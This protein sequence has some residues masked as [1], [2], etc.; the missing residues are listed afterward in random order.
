MI[1][2]ESYFHRDE[3]HDVLRRWIHDE[4]APADADLITRLVHFNSACV[5]RYLRVFSEQVLQSV[6]GQQL[7]TRRA[8]VKSCLKDAIIAHPPYRNA[9]VDELV[10]QYAEHPETQYRET[11]F[12]ATLYFAD[13]GGSETYVGSQRVKRVRRLAE[14]VARRIADDLFA[15][16]KRRADAL[17]EARARAR[18]I[19]LAKLVTAHEEMVAEFAG[20]EARIVEDLRAGRPLEVGRLVI[21]DVAGLKVIAEEGEYGRVLEA[22]HALPGAKVF[23]VE[24]HRGRYNATNVAVRYRPDKERI[25]AQPPGETLLAAMAGRGLDAAATRREFEAFVRRAEDEV[26]IEVI[27]SSYQEML[28]S[29]IG[30]C[31]HEDR[32]LEQRNGAPY[33]GYLAKNVEYL[34]EYL[35]T[36]ATCPGAKTGELPIKLWNRYLPEY[37]DEVI[38]GLLGVPPLRLAE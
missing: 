26:V 20:A 29:E 15:A 11:P 24:V 6:H 21:N 12:H 13:K 9:R 3:F 5:S 30:R 38:K 36:L 4:P 22:L 37:F 33:R 2:V 28:E 8:F 16:I 18:G 31:I 27:V 19:P 14:K 32:I 34:V 17:A 25:L 1:H 7:R 35:F 10:R 23:E